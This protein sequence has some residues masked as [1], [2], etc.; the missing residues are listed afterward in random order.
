[1]NITSRL[2]EFL[3]FLDK[4]QSMEELGA[5]TLTVIGHFRLS[6]VASG[7]IAGSKAATPERF[8]FAHWPPGLL[9]RYI[10]ED[11]Q[12]LDPVPRWARGTGAPATIGQILKRLKPK[13]PGRIVIEIVKEYGCVE[14]VCVPMRAADGAIGVVSMVGDRSEFSPE[15][16]RDLVA[17]GSLVFRRAE[18]INH[19]AERAQAAPILTIREIELLPFL[20]HGHSDREIAAL[21]NISQ[22]TVRFHLKNVRNKIGAVSRTHLAAKVVALGFASL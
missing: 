20:V 18:S 14:G 10:S 5:R 4:A 21:N 13:D 12:A 9:E 17:I 16:F 3:E 15:E 19:S 11:L 6:V 8:H 1:M 22:A 7:I 2:S